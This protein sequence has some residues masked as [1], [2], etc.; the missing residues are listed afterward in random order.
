M[1]G[2]SEQ[3][4]GR[5]RSRL[6]PVHSY[7]LKKLVPM[8][9][10]FFFILFNYT[11]LRDMKDTLVVTAAGGGHVI[12]FLKFCGVVP[13]A[14]V[15]M[16]IFSFLANKLS[17]QQLFF[18]SVIPFLVFF[19]A[20]AL[21]IYPNA[22]SLSATNSA[23][24]LMEHGGSRV[25]GLVDMYRNWVFSVFYI[26]SELWGSVVLSLLFW[27]F[28]NDTTRISEAKRYY[29]L[30]GLGGNFALILSGQLIRHFS[31]I[32]SGDRYGMS[33]NILMTFVVFSGIIILGLY[34]F[35]NNKV[36]TDPRF[37]AADE[38]K[39]KKSK[40]K[41]GFIEG[42]KVLGR[43]KYLGCL[44]IIVM[45]YGICI[46]FVEVT[47]KDRLHAQFPTEAA[48]QAFMGNFSTVTGI[49]TILMML[50]VGG[51]MMRR[52]GWGRSAA[53]TPIVL[54]VTGLGFFAF[55]LI[56]NYMG[57]SFTILGATPLLMAVLFGATQNIMSKSAK[58]SLFDPTKEMAYIPLDQDSKVKG[59][60]AIDVVGAR[61]GKSG[62]ALVQMGLLAMLGGQVIAMAPYVAVLLLVVILAWLGSVGSLSKQF[63]QK[64]AEKAAA[65]AAEAAEQPAAA[66]ADAQLTP[67]S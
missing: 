63:A 34:W 65:D 39:K 37:F 62:G 60:A 55:V 52:F 30:F 61:L 7:E 11:V 14:I 33:V 42:L 57:S 9:L 49:V 24:W 13:A 5:W 46:N 47:W 54:G 56:G 29:A 12:P 41:L 17:K 1:S 40:P 45:S 15:F 66:G 67:A 32:Y 64:Q 16:V 27:G 19:G 25:A 4:F 35:M 28:A 59:K 31:T 8:L 48:Y 43:S 51:N 53:F 2:T 20:F 18:A 38:V 26:M 44:A 36:L 6:W 50:F 3:E 23:N 22:S 58:Y 10:M 21:F